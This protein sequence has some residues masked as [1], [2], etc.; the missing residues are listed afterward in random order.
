MCLYILQRE[1]DGRTMMS[2]LPDDVIRDILHCL[3]DHRDVI[4]TG[5]T[6]AR[7]L[8]LSEEK[9]VWRNLCQ[10]HFDNKTWNTVVRKGESL[11]SLGWK[12]LYGRLVK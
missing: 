3:H 9:R 7:A 12:K 4:R 5:M 1:E 10:F 2:D 8:E 6:E 11:E